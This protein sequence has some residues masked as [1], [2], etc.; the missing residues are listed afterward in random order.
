MLAVKYE[1]R[2][3]IQMCMGIQYMSV[4]LFD[5]RMEVAAAVHHSK[6]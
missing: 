6:A 5:S 4:L 3:C 2:M 1:E